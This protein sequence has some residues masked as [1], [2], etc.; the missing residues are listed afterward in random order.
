VKGHGK[1]K[2]SPCLLQES[3]INRN[4]KEFIIKVS[5]MGK[6]CLERFSIKNIQENIQKNIQKNIQEGKCIHI[7]FFILVSIIGLFIRY[8]GV[9]FISGDMKVFFIPWFNVI[10]ESGGINALKMQVGDYN[11]LYQTIIAIMTYFDINCA[12]QYKVFS[13][14]FDYILAY[15]CSVLFCKL[16]LVKKW[17][18]YFN[19][20]YTTVLFLPTVILN[21]AF[22]GQCDSIWTSF[23]IMCLCSFWRKK[24]A[25]GCFFLGMAFAFKLQAIFILPFI[26]CLWFYR[27]D[28]SIFYLI[29]TLLTFWGSGIVA[30]IYGRSLLEPFKIYM[31]QSSEYEKMYLN[32]HSFW[33]L[34]GKDFALLEYFAIL[35]TMVLC[36]VFSYLVVIKRIKIDTSEQFINV[37]I[38]FVWTCNIFLPAMH[39]RYTYLLDVLLVLISF[40]NVRYSKYA[41]LSFFG[42]LLTYS[43]YLFQN[44]SLNQYFALLYVIGW[45]HYSYTI[46]IINPH[47][48]V[49]SYYPNKE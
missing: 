3:S 32:I 48:D 34:V 47:D 25:L 26:V 10:K 14:F 4:I 29:I 37:A 24:Y 41:I 18:M 21:S 22:W 49:S 15:S 45:I 27:R 1:K 6:Y 33:L 20:V 42:S 40:V 2:N 19:L 31:H 23:V 43:A 13:V 16:A 9:D 30:Y 35:F 8:S 7:L 17:S 12:I 46:L 36:I 5:S 39:E 11:L 38:W 28:R 44:Y